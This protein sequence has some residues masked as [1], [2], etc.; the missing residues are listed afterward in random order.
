VSEPGRSSLPYGRQSIDDED[1][2][3]VVEALRSEFLTTGPKVDEFERGLER[4]TGARHA[5]VLNS[6]TSALHA[7]YAAAGVGRD[8]EIITT[9]LT[10]SATA[11]AALYLGA[12]PVFVDIEAESGLIDP[13]AV[14]AAITPR[15]RAIVPV[16]YAGHPAPYEELREIASRHGLALIADAAHSLGARY[17]GRL[18]G[19]LADQTIVSFHPVK[20]IT[21]GEGG[22][23]LTAD[24]ATDV[25]V[26]EFRSHGITRDRA[27]LENDDGPW[28]YEVQS[29]GYNYRLSDIHSALGISQLRKLDRF[30]T[31]RRAIA[32]EYS[33]GLAEIPGLKLPLTRPGVDHAWHLYV[34]RTVAG[35]GAR[36]E[37][38]DRLRER[39]L[40][41]Q[42]HYIPVHLHPLYRE[43]GY[44]AGQFP[45]AEQFYEAA[46]SIPMFPGLTDKDVARIIDDV[47][48]AA[49]AL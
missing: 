45:N 12:R 13:T 35:K 7:A 26:R 24:D 39:G 42:V 20:A 22:A 5:V 4:T 11:N 49:T 43:F 23:V 34:I 29:L 48:K 36:R 28:Y 6:G 40:G 16:D 17:H 46:V 15:T 9:P 27:R 33:A 44:R 47:R 30:L 41:V 8:D 31:R 3:A 19:T 21:A 1:V 37:L 38:Y 10:F 14:E 18:V 25:L 32:H 2:A